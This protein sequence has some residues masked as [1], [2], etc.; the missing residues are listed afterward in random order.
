MSIKLYHAFELH[1]TPTDT[2]EQWVTRARAIL[3][4]LADLTLRQWQ[5]RAAI[6]EH[7]LGAALGWHRPADGWLAR[8]RR[9]GMRE[10][11]EAHRGFRAP[12]VDV[13]VSVLLIRDPLHDQIHGLHFAENPAMR[14]ALL[15]MP[16]V[17]AAPY[18]DQTD[19]IPEGMTE[20]Q[21]EARRALWERL[22]PRG[23]VGDAG[24]THELVPVPKALPEPTDADV[25]AFTLT[26]A[27]RVARMLPEA[28][29]D[30]MALAVQ[31]AGE[32]WNLSRCRRLVVES[33]DHDHPLRPILAPRVEA[34]LAAHPITAKGL[35]L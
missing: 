34:A 33:H 10:L 17:T 14:Q 26:L 15:A 9:E 22:V 5:V 7:D 4:P 30:E 32:S 19:D 1:L 35:G 20:A 27:D 21:W 24:V 25:L 23:P 29:A 8:V 6:R 2:V 12:D 11:E 28:I 13:G 16:E 3:T 31:A 18:Q